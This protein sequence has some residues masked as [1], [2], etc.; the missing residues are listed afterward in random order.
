MFIKKE[1]YADLNTDLTQQKFK[2]QQLLDER[3]NALSEKSKVEQQLIEAKDQ[4]AR[5]KANVSHAEHEAFRR[6]KKEVVGAIKQVETDFTGIYTDQLLNMLYNLIVFSGAPLSLDQQYVQYSLRHFGLVSIGGTSPDDIHV[7]SGSN[8]QFGSAVVNNYGAVTAGKGS[9]KIHD[10]L[11][12]KDLQLITPLNVN[13]DEIFKDGAYV[14]I[15]NKFSNLIG[16]P[17][18]SAN[19]IALAK[20][21]A[22]EM[23]RLKASELHNAQMMRTS[24]IGLSKNKNITAMNLYAGIEQGKTFFDLNSSV[25][26]KPEDV[27]KIF[28]TDVPDNLEAFQK[29]KA[30]LMYEFLTNM[31]VNALENFK[32][33]RAITAEVESNN[34]L[35]EASGNSYLMTQQRPIDLLN[36][37]LGSNLNVDF[38][39]KSIENAKQ[40]VGV[41]DD[42]STDDNEG[43]SDNGTL[44]DGSK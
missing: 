29:A 32:A 26:E 23:A 7:I 30:N 33:E 12:G 13:D 42:N 21:Y 5:E 17:T 19:D 22:R 37:V 10:E 4:I 8:T 34:G 6:S 41:T 43:S 44:Y 3:D 1:E 27:L 11:T 24:Y 15:A 36:I 28:N 9:M 18:G 35:I 39:L 14:V 2:A 31:G 20:I 16:T 25:N 38:N 40:A